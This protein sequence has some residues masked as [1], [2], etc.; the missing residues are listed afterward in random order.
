MKK[1]ILDFKKMKGVEPITFITSYSYPFAQTAEKA[2]IEIIL[3]GDS[4]GMV[5]LG[6]KSTNLVVM[7][8]M[9]SFSKAVR[10]GAPETFVVGDMSQGSYEVSN[11]DA[12]R[13]ALR[14]VKEAFCDAIKLEG[15]KRMC[16]RVKAISDAGILVIGHLGLT[17]QSVASFGGYR[18]QA[19]TIESFDQTVEDALALQKAG[20]CMI[21]LE[22][23]P[24]ESTKQIVKQ[25]NIPILGIGAGIDCDGQLVIMHDLMGF[26]QDFRPWFAKCYIPEV[27]NEFDNYIL[28]AKQS[29][30]NL[31]DLGRK[32]R[33]DG[34]LKLAELA[35]KKYISDVKEKNFPSFEYTYPLKN[36]ELLELRKSQYWSEA[37]EKSI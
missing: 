4:G 31:K 13:N 19:K 9:I 36:E 24:N 11:E 14:F 16:D 23:L 6:Y 22:A 34:L 15:G 12:I 35:I 7:D 37:I 29:H 17:P 21:L 33:S 25:L 30:L 10:R 28:E 5:E 1:S 18:V 8:E 26:Y 3:I 2:G 27:I 32:T 20:A